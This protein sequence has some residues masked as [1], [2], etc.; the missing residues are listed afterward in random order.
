MVLGWRGGGLTGWCIAEIHQQDEDHKILMQQGQAIHALEDK[1][2]LACDVIARQEKEI[3]AL[4]INVHSINTKHMKTELRISGI[5]QAGNETLVE[6]CKKFFT[7]QL[8]VTEDIKIISATRRG[9]ATEGV[10]IVKIAHQS[11]K[12]AIF[13]RVKNLKGLKNSKDKS[14]GISS[15]LPDA[16]YETDLKKRLIIKANKAMPPAYKQKMFLK[17]GELYVKE[18]PFVNP[19][20]RSSAKDLFMLSKPD[21]LNCQQLTTSEGPDL[22]EE[23]S[24]FAGF[25]C[26]TADLTEVQRAYQHFCLR[27]AD[28]THIMA[29]YKLPG[30]DCAYDEG[31]FDDA[32]HGGGRRL[33][34]LLVDGNYLST[35]VVVVRYYGMKRLGP[36]RFELINQTAEAA[37]TNLT[38]NNTALSVLQIFQQPER[39]NTVRRR[40]KPNSPTTRTLRHPA[41]PSTQKSTPVASLR[42]PQTPPMSTTMSDP[43]LTAYHRFLQDNV[44]SMDSNE[45][46]GHTQQ[47]AEFR[48]MDDYDSEERNVADTSEAEQDM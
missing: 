28:A 29:A 1:I 2:K 40:T 18:K 24:R 27:F 3:E 45:D 10:V 26:L 6:A 20:K 43:P 16:E 17:K 15:N 46:E 25:A 30:T 37:L 39:S 44:S 8:K 9:D 42:F 35:L 5:I 13:D 14:F 22:L 48:S 21:L 11:Q 36:K 23:G 7:N 33:L 41:P 31:Y 38:A 12:K 32:E 19:L 47:S 34:R 4:K